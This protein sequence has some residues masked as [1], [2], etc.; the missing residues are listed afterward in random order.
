[1]T[2]R[3]KLDQL[4][5]AWKLE[6]REHKSSFIVYMILRLLVIIV[7]ITQFWKGNYEHAFLCVLT[8]FLL[9]VPSFIQMTFK[10]ELPATLEIIILLFIFAAEILGEIN[11]FYY[12]FE[13]WDTILHTLNGFLAAAIGF[14]LVDLLNNSGKIKF[15]LSPLF[16]AIV[17]FCFSMTI[18][19]FW[20]FFEYTMDVFFG[21]NT[22]KDTLLQSL[23]YIPIE[24]DGVRVAIDEVKEVIING[25]QVKGGYVDIGLVDTMEDLLVNMIG[26]VAFSFFGFFYTKSKGKSKVVKRFVP[27]RKKKSR[28]YLEL[29][30]KE[31]KEELEKNKEE[32]QTNNE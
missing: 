12:K 6:L 24:P 32:L 21:M 27:T 7:M 10:I 28:D 26:A 9:I 1:M 30:K 23:S 17:A 16:T 31:S 14:S 3:N 22:Q 15:M 13:N 18:G 5:K 20:E 8:L 2:F 25:M 4:G 11:D 19:V 29:I